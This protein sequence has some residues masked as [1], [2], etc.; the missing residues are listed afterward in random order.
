MS[1]PKDNDTKRRDGDG[2]SGRV[3]FDDRGNSVWE[4]QL[5]TGV[6]SRD[7]ST[8][9]LKRLNLDDLSIAE[10]GTH[11]KP[12][13][14]DQTVRKRELTAT[15]NARSIGF[16]PYDSSPLTPTQSSYDRAR[17]AAAP[18]EVKPKERVRTLDDMRKLSEAIKRKKLEESR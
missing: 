11:R 14:T 12:D 9:R 15:E 13:V 7:V 3:G 6:Y 16:N 4:W 10:T 8:Q 17:A 5:E 1:D 2:R 18:P